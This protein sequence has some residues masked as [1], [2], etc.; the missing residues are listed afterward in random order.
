SCFSATAAM[1]FGPPFDALI[2]EVAEGL[3]GLSHPV[4]LF[5]PLHRAP[6]AVAGVQQLVGELLGHA[7]ASTLSREPHQ[8]ATREGQPAVGANLDRD[9][10]GRAA[11]ASR[12]DLEQRRSVA[13][14]LVED[15]ER[16]LLPLPSGP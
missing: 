1:S 9:L 4:G 7:P 11:H 15:L 8:P 6:R 2:P 14:R 12:L 10:V 16:L 5:L 3:V 13:E